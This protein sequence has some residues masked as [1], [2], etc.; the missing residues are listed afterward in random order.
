MAEEQNPNKPLKQH[1]S[2]RVF[3]INEHKVKNDKDEIPAEIRDNYK[4]KSE[5]YIH[6]LITKFSKRLEQIEAEKPELANSEYKEVA[7]LLG[8]LDA[9]MNFNNLLSETFGM[10]LDITDYC[11]TIDKVFQDKKQ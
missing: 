7:K 6:A 5:Y 4:S 2:T 11:A 3:L 1:I 9:L 10:D 8:S